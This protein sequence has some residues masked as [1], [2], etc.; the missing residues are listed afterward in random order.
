MTSICQSVTAF[1]TRRF[2]NYFKW[3]NFIITAKTL[4]DFKNSLLYKVSNAGS[5]ND[6]VNLIYW[7]FKYFFAIS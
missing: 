4:E 1:T 6:M 2:K 7:D 5:P 3:S